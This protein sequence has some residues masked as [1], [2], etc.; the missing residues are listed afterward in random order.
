MTCATGAMTSTAP[1]IVAN[2]F[3][4]HHPAVNAGDVERPAA[5]LIQLVLNPDACSGLYDAVELVSGIA[6]CRPIVNPLTRQLSES[7]R[8]VQ[9]PAP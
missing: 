9:Q 8:Q 4:K 5:N 2:R 3:R 7:R 6:C 1:D